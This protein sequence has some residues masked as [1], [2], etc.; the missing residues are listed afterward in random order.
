MHTSNRFITNNIN[1][2]VRT[3]LG[4]NKTGGVEHFLFVLSIFLYPFSIANHMLYLIPQALLIATSA[5]S[6]SKRIYLTDALSFL[7]GIA[8][9]IIALVVEFEADVPNWDLSLKLIVNT[10]SIILIAGTQRLTFSDKTLRYIR[11]TCFLWIITA[12]F[13]YYKSGVTSIS[14]IVLA[15]NTTSE[16]D[17]SKL[18]GLAE[19]IRQFFLTKNI[20]AMFV[21]SVFSLYLYISY[22]LKKKV[23]IIDFS[24][25][26]LTSVIFLS[27][28]SII[29]IIALYGFYVFL[30]A[31][32]LSKA[33]VTIPFVTAGCLFFF[34]FFDLK[35]S[36]DGASQ[37]L[38]LWTYFFE[39]CQ[40]FIL[41]GNGV[42][43]LN[44]TLRRAIGID[45]FHM[46]FMNQIGAYGIFHFIAFSLFLYFIFA[47][48]GKKKPRLILIA[49]YFLNVLFQTYGYE[50]GNL[51]LFISMYPP[52]DSNSTATKASIPRIKFKIRRNN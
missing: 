39:H 8:A 43:I 52:I 23:T 24:L 36:G 13:A 16:V 37:R 20:T 47:R 17:S 35:N 28:Q 4:V 45:N 15:F 3:S 6:I 26:F 42:N 44:Q 25:F 1:E 34:T 50:F 38:E 7:F 2:P 48:P 22:C 30:R 31:G 27:R 18:Y 10:I 9:F 11:Y 12:I 32:Y 46:F 19:P 21:V 33:L 51:F 40:D 29:T 49:G 14:S 41:T 5:V